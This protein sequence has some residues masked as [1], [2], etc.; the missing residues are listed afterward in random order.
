MFN[1]QMHKVFVITYLLLTA[2]LHVPIHK[3]LLQEV[4]YMLQ[5]AAS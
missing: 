2:L 1:Q 5:L 4:V 3:Y